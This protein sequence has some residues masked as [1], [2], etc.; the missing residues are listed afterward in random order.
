MTIH[1]YVIG[2]PEGGKLRESADPI[3]VLSGSCTGE[4]SGL[5]LLTVACMCE[6]MTHELHV[7]Q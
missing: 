3:Q 5:S 6:S 1:M 4:S 7:K 2:G